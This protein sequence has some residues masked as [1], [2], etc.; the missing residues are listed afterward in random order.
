M[1]VLVDS[2]VLIEVMR[3]RDADLA[4]RWDVLSNSATSILYSPVTEAELWAGARLNEH[5][6]LTNLFLTLICV[7]ITADIGRSAGKYLRSFR[8]SHGTQMGDALIAASAVSR[9]AQLWTRNRKHFPMNDL[10]LFE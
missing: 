5:K 2:D 4:S 7:P 8:K 6:A 3:A 10:A 1:T 9:G